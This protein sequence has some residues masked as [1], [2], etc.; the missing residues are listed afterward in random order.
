MTKQIISFPEGPKTPNLAEEVTTLIGIM[1]DCR[2]SVRASPAGPEAIL[3]DRSYE[4]AKKRLTTIL[5]SLPFHRFGQG[6]NFGE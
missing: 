2:I 6:I 3:L 4:E 5:N 1:I